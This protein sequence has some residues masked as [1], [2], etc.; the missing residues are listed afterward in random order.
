MD[1]WFS[2]DMPSALV[3]VVVSAVAHG[4]FASSGSIVVPALAGLASTAVAVVSV[5]IANRAKN[6]AEASEHARVAAEA[7]R[8]R[9]DR[10]QRL[11]SAIRDMFVGIANLIRDIETYENNNREWF[12]IFAKNGIGGDNPPQPVQPS[13]SALLALV[14][15]ARLEAEDSRERDM[16]D[17]VSKSIESFR[18]MD[19]HPRKARLASLWEFVV[20]WRHAA[21]PERPAAINAIQ[22]GRA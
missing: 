17:A 22:S 13:D 3:R 1:F 9:R 7:A 20:K 10:Q 18:A 5:S 8:A 12:K 19:L 4:G 14:A 2:P 21:E 11:D 6:I 15:A 16:L